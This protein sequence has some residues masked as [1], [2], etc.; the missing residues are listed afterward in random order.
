M[1]ITFVTIP[2]EGFVAVSTAERFFSRVGADVP[3]K[4]V[5]PDK[6]SVANITLEGFV[7]HLDVFGQVPGC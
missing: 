6:L 4:V 2:V 7:Y 3:Q 5:F 1:Q